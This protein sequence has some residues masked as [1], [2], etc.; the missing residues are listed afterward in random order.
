MMDFGSNWVS[1]LAHWVEATPTRTAVVKGDASLSYEA[2]W[3]QARQFSGYLQHSG[4]K[5]GERVAFYLPKQL[6]AVAALIG[7][8]MAGCVA[9][10]VNPVLKVDQL[11]HILKDC[12]ARLL[13]TQKARLRTIADLGVTLDVLCIDESNS[14]ADVVQ[15]EPGQV[16]PVQTE[17]L[18]L[19]FYTSGSTGKPKGVMVTHDNLSA[20]AE[21]VS[22]YLSLDQN[23]KILSLLPWSFDYGFNQLGNAFHVGAQLVLMDFLLPQDVPRQIE[24][25]G[26]TVLGCVP[27]LW[28]QLMDVKWS[29]SARHS[30]RILT[31]TGGRMPRPLLERMQSQFPSAKIYLMYGLTEAF[32]STY[33]DPVELEYRPDSIG[34][35]VPGEEV[36]VVRSDGTLCGPDEVGEIVHTGRFVSPGYWRDEEKSAHRFKAPPKASRY[37]GSNCYSVYS[38]DKARYDEDGFIYFI[39]RDDEMIKTSGYRVSP[40]EVEEAAMQCTQ[41]AQAFACGVEDERLGQSIALILRPKNPND[42]DSSVFLQE[43]KTKTPNYMA[44]SR[45]IWLDELPMSPN[46]KL[47]RTALSVIVREE[48]EI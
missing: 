21:V 41:V 8:A 6:E 1:S 47:D 4:V 10:P 11:A 39:G 29:E 2:L 18:C 13:V 26:V 40:T 17:D 27:P 9:V 28:H 15:T 25:F 46:G 43:F 23:D 44:P 7:T 32:R 24:R 37:F 12:G 33:L 36:L 20:G 42:K 16:K 38:G 22:G 35:A 19:I 5:A 45:V 3:R 30:L 48:R 14:W 31:N 34:K